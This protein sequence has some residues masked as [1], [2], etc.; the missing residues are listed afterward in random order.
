MANTALMVD[1]DGIAVNFSR[2]ADNES[3]VLNFKWEIIS[4]KFKT[5][6]FALTQTL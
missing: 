2:V 4:N 6:S 5:I 1:R 3:S